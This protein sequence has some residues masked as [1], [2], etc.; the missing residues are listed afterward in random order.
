MQWT[1]PDADRRPGIPALFIAAQ[2]VGKQPVTV[3]A[4]NLE[5]RSGRQKSGHHLTPQLGYDLPHRL[6]PGDAWTH[7][8]DLEVV[9]EGL[10]SDNLTEKALQK[11]RVTTT[12]AGSFTG[13]IPKYVRVAV[14][15]ALASAAPPAPE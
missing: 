5:L 15:R 12:A 4:F 6:E 14:G 9:A 2:N 1:G 13:K 11:A 7:W 10:R 8:T 3:N